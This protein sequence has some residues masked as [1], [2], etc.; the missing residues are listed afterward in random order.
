MYMK[1]KFK[2][3]I[4]DWSDWQQIGKILAQV[5]AEFQF[6]IGPIGSMPGSYSPGAITCFNSRLVRLA[7]HSSSL[8][9]VNSSVSIPDWSDWQQSG[10]A[11]TY[12]RGK[13]QFQIGPI[14][15]KPD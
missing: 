4:P 1:N 13:F 9:D 15:R 11:E 3:S 10:K 14:G 7:A 12:R 8:K 5:I 6:Q 2:V